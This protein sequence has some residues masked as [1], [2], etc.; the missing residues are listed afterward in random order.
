MRLSSAAA[1]SVGVAL[2]LGAAY[3]VD[4][5]DGPELGPEDVRTIVARHLADKPTGLS[6]EEVGSIAGAHLRENP[7]IVVEAIRAYQQREQEAEQN[8]RLEIVQA[9]WE[10]IAHSPGDPVLG[11][12]DGDVTLVEFFDY[13]CGYCRRAFPEVQA[14]HQND[15]NL[16]IVLKE[17]PILGPVSVFAS[18]ASL[19]AAKQDLASEFHTATMQ[20]EGE[21][22]EDRVIEIARQVGL[23]IDRLRRD[24][25][26]PEID[27][28][29]ER[30][31]A[32][33]EKLGIRGTPAFLTRTE[34]IPGAVGRE[35]LKA[36][37]EQAREKAS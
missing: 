22:T 24:M 28:I 29:I 8:A 1:F 17:F 37:V 18:R 2:A 33:A 23:D 31:Y 30:N 6:R 20:A 10:E 25:D 9:N 26:D 34:I 19:A 36:V 21:L 13:R 35:R 15:P 11:N 14:L 7:E 32:L 4:L 5:D 16:R 12:P 27:E 3:L